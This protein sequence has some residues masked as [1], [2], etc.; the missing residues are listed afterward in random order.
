MVLQVSPRVSLKQGVSERLKLLVLETS[1]GTKALS[2]VGSN[3]TSL[4]NG[5]CS[6]IG[7]APD[8]GSGRCGFESRQSPQLYPPKDIY[9]V[10][11]KLVSCCIWDAETA[12]SSPAYSTVLVADVG[13][14]CVTVNHVYGGSIPL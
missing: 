12:G 13:S 11:A 5:G 9:R 4:T 1:E 3:P 10:V 2:S 6:S 8:C 14:L 7:R